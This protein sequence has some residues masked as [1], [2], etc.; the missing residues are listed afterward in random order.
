MTE[1]LF[2]LAEKWS[3]VLIFK[4][5]YFNYKS[6]G[7]LSNTNSKQ[8]KIEALVLSKIKNCFSSLKIDI[9]RCYGILGYFAFLPFFLY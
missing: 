7:A 4:G 1:R 9:K 5:P 3:K 6:V 8:E 2:S